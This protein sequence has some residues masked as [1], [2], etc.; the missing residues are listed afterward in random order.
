MKRA[1]RPDVFNEDAI[2]QH[3]IGQGLAESMAKPLARDL[4]LI[5]PILLRELGADNIDEILQRTAPK[6]HLSETAFW[7]SL[8]PY[9]VRWEEDELASYKARKEV[10]PS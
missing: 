3:F 8:T 1:R 5:V 9:L 4:K 7:P 2:V 10:G 6:L